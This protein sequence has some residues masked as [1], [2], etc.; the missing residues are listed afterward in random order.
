MRN[1]NHLD[2]S[3]DL[4]YIWLILLLSLLQFG[5]LLGDGA[6]RARYGKRKRLLD[7]KLYFSGSRETYF[8]PFNRILCVDTY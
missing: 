4:Q 6:H 1:V 8:L 7:A 2:L 3:L 5:L